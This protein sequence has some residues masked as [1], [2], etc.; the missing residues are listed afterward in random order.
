MLAPAAE[1]IKARQCLTPARPRLRHGGGPS[2]HHRQEQRRA[3][4]PGYP[5]FTPRE[6][7]VECLV[8]DD[9]NHSATYEDPPPSSRDPDGRTPKTIAWPFP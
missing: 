1:A 4:R 7:I 3:A 2:Q 9:R 8:I 6:V 5:C